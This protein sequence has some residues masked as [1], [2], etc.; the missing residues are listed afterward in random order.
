MQIYI[1]TIN[2]SRNIL[3]KIFCEKIVPSIDFHKKQISSY[4][5][6]SHK[7]LNEISL[8]LPNFQK[9]RKEKRGSITSLIKGFI[10]LAHKGISNYL[11]NK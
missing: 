11:H 10:G 8:I 3:L 4:N 9:T 1:I 5:C 6:M 2:T 7:I